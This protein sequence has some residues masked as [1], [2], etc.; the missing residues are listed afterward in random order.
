M[1]RDQ[2]RNVLKGIFEDETGK[3]L[4]QLPDDTVMAE[5]FELDSVDMVSLIMQVE[6]RFRVRMT[7]AELGEV[8]NVGSLLDLIE[9]KI[10]A[11]AAQQTRLAA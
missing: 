3:T 9:A 4:D 10:S 8:K 11:T 1:Q 7:H 2:I 5:E 6:S